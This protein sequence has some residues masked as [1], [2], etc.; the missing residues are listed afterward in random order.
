MDFISYPY[1]ILLI[2]G[3]ALKKI[4]D[5]NKTEVYVQILPQWSILDAWAATP[6]QTMPGCQTAPYILSV[7]MDE[8]EAT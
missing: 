2:S 8:L 7:P 5:L 6:C 1:L 4:W 3:E